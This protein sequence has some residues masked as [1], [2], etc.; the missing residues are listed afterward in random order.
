MTH[1]DDT[2]LPAG[3]HV[4]FASDFHLGVPDAASSLAREKKVVAWLHAV[5]P[6]AGHIIL[7]GDVFDFWFEYRDVV[8]RGFTRLLGTLSALTDSGIPITLFTGNH[9]MW[10]FG[11][12][13]QETGIR[14]QK[15]PATWRVNGK[16]FFMAHGDGLGKGDFTYRFLKFIF[17]S[18][19]LQG[20]FAAL[21]PRIGMGIA[22]KSSKASRL[23]NEAYEATFT[24]SIQ[25]APSDRQANYVKMLH[26]SQ[27]HDY[28]VM[29]HYHCP[30]RMPIGAHS[31]Y[32][33]LGDWM[34][35]CMYADFDGNDIQLV[36]Y[37][38]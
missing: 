31:L 27:P 8:P 7:L 4:Y 22:T 13:A 16:A 2:I 6:T 12:L 17:D 38:L 32:L 25:T 23:K 34:S 15:G 26:A 3:K 33:N 10:T 29:G 14:V 28:Y 1:W 21:H 35:T 5:A 11:Y 24:K 37:K 36:A 19:W 20:T 9:D 30:V 18:S